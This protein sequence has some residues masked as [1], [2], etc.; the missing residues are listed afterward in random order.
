GI[1]YLLSSDRKAINWKTVGI[2]LALQLV[3]GIMILKAPFVKEVFSL[4]ASFFVAVL[5]FTEAGADFVLGNW[6][7]FV[8]YEDE[9]GQGVIEIGYVFAFKVLPTIVF[10][11]ALSSLLYYLGILQIII[12]GFAWVM[13]KTMGLTGPESL[14]AAANVFI[15]QTEAP[16]VVKPYLE[17]MSRSEIL[18]LMTGGMATIAGGVF[19][20]YVGFLGGD[21]PVAR[22]IFAT[23]LL[24]ASIMSAP[25]AIIAAKILLPESKK[26]NLESQSLDIPRQDVGSNVLDA[27]SRGTTD[28]IKLAVN[29]GAMLLVFTAFVAMINAMIYYGI[30]TWTGLNDYVVE[31]TNGR[32]TGFN[33]EYILGVLFAPLAWLLGVSWED[34]TLVGQLLGLKTTLNE[35]F[36]YAALEGVQ[37]DISEKSVIIATYALCGFANFASIGIQIGG[38]SAIAPGQRRNLTELGINS[39]IGGTV[40]CFLTA[41][42]AGIMYT[43]TPQIDSGVSQELSQL[44]K[45][46]IEQLSYDLSVTIPEDKKDALQG[47]M[48]IAFEYIGKGDVLLDF[49]QPSEFVDSL[50]VNGTA[51]EA[52]VKNDHIILPKDN[53]NKGSNTVRLHF[54]LGD[55]SLNRN[56]DFLYTLFVPDRASTSI[57]FF[58]Q[59]NL[60][61]TYQLDL[62]IPSDWEAIANG[63]LVETIDSGKG[64]KQLIFG[65]TKAFSTYVF[66]FTAGAF[67]K[68]TRTL[69]GRE[70]NMLYRESDTEKV[71]RNI[72]DIFELHAQS[73]DWMEDYTGMEM[74]F[75]K[76]DFALIP[77]FQYGGMEHIGAIFY[78][79]SSLMLD[80]DPTENRLL[81]RASLIAHETSHMWFGDL[82]T[83]DW[84]N[85]VW[86]KE[87][88][89]NFLAAKI[90]N[91]GFP[92]I[93]HDLRFLFAHVPSALGE[94][95]TEGSHPI[96]QELDN[97]KNAG[98]LYGRIIYQKAPVVMK[99]LETLIGEEALQA[100][101]Q[102]YLQTY[103]FDNAR[104]DDL[105]AILD[106]KSDLDL[107]SWSQVWVKEATMP[108]YRSEMVEQEND[109][110]EIS[111]VAA[112]TSPSERYW[113]QQTTVA[114]FYSDSIQLISAQLEG[115]KTTLGNFPKPRAIL[116]NASPMAYGYFALDETSQAYLLSEVENIEQAVVRGAS[117]LALE[118]EM[119]DGKL[120]PGRLLKAVESALQ[121]ETE[122]LNR[123]RLLGLASELFWKFIPV[124]QR[125]SYATDLEQTLW[126]LL[127]QA[128]DA[129][130]RSAYWSTYAGIGFTAVA[131]QQLLDIYNGQTTIPGLN[132]TES[133]RYA[134]AKNLA[135]R[136][137]D[138]SDDIITQLAANLKNPDR[139]RR[140]AF[141]K[142]VLSN[143][144]AERDAFFEGLKVAENRAIEP[145]ASEA[146]GLLNHPLRSAEAID[147]IR[148][149][150][151][152]LPEIQ[153]T[154]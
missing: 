86:L 10:F 24:T 29:V 12:K 43:P 81:G 147:Y 84:F 61:A 68:A 5:D 102:D 154:G 151:E 133:R 32:F 79:E 75:Q 67:K 17:R 69:D 112:N 128:S 134:L 65:E 56:E 57:P 106:E 48:T 121:S 62:T 59:P 90:V 25:A 28:G 2:G 105:I 64:Q 49:R 34:S 91:P 82:V 116:T 138:Q 144:K 20:A 149:S 83:M 123:Q 130:A 103:S 99:Q 47:A 27:I 127:N 94:D 4:L 115:E 92:E 15:G 146:V 135:I 85:D 131:Q 41:I 137:P 13:V 33:V 6:P 139:K 39:L 60:K 73:I 52:T 150:L 142:P 23:H 70:M 36:A 143:D 31:T 54:E 7:D 107:A 93:D 53:L 129:S 21:D 16:L 108:H 114:L 46:Q 77:G 98:T 119:L 78:R 18:C 45:S 111:I 40:A 44:R 110:V 113:T 1:C 80:E 3:L 101:L 8:A 97:L 126:E 38:I 120:A 109:Q 87:V 22:Q 153:A 72:D 100:G 118:E 122:P 42:I 71:D 95:R 152:L 35:F 124:D 141:I 148:P 136:M 88:F 63:P 37:K 145:W 66:A 89:A 125:S 30:G 11:S 58:D 55:L 9:G 96:Q 104:W 14:A 76:F 51:L 74:P 19:A 117:W 132:I 140:L 26:I 50:S